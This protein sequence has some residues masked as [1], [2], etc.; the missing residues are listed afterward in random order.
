MEIISH[1]SVLPT[2][3]SLGPSD[4]VLS[5]ATLGFPLPSQQIQLAARHGFAGICVRAAEW[6]AETQNGTTSRE[7][8]QMAA[9]AG[10]VVADIDCLAPVLGSGETGDSA[11][12]TGATGV[13][14]TGAGATGAGAT[15]ATATKPK[16]FGATSDDV[17][18]CAES[19][20]AR[21]VNLVLQKNRSAKAPKTR[22]EIIEAA[23]A[24]CT[25][26]AARAAEAG[27]LV[28]L[29]PVPFMDIKDAAMALE[30]TSQV[31]HP[32]LG[33]Q[34]D[35]WHHFRGPL[36]GDPK[37]GITP[38]G[39]LAACEKLAQLDGSRILAVQICDSASQQGHPFE[40]TMKRRLLPGQ[41]E[42]PLVEFLRALA[43][44]G[45]QAPVSV[46]IF[47]DPQTPEQQDSTAQAAAS[48]TRALLDAARA[49]TAAPVS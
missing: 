46:E 45:C 32:N 38:A 6:L 41:G 24:D 18:V 31:D 40:D 44:S 29:E 27:V 10:L 34:V 25:H 1:P 16:F 14:A 30:I 8:R 39:M 20:G 35:S 12:G 42:F 17:F 9:D 2:Q 3:P 4:L 21:S 37:A 5:S 43:Q 7:L 15:G 11:T 22:A 47:S 49:T 33:V 28:H 23:A 48:Q 13:G 26:M 36:A 19:L